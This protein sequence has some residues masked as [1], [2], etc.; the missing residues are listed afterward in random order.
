MDPAQEG[1]RAAA[2]VTL[3]GL[4]AGG[5]LA[6]RG[7]ERVTVAQPKH[8]PSP[9]VQLRSPFTGEPAS[10]ATA[11]AGGTLDV[12]YKSAD[13]TLGHRWYGFRR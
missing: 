5:L 7:G 9:T 2:V 11:Q 12:L 13:A 10:P 8:S 3:A 4:V 1:Y 6:L